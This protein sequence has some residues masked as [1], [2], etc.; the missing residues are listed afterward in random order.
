MAD[1]NT[2]NEMAKMAAQAALAKQEE[3][4]YQKRLE[5]KR[6]ARAKVSAVGLDNPFD[7]PEEMKDPKFHYMIVNDSPG[8][9]SLF[10]AR[11]YEL[12]TDKAL[13]RYLNQTEGDP[14]RFATGMANPAWAYLMKIEKELFEEDQER[15]RREAEEKFQSLGIAPEDLKFAKDASIDGVVL[16][17]D[18][19]SML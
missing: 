18:K 15:D 17:K 4:N 12:V 9:V 7:I 13:A 10:Q 1:P 14:V 5:E 2:Q 19:D 6:K 3:D 16:N 8:R 11:G